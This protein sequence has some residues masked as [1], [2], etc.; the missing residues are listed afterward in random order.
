MENQAD[1]LPRTR[2]VVTVPKH[3]GFLDAVISALPDDAYA[4]SGTLYAPDKLLL[5]G[6]AQASVELQMTE[7]VPDQYL[8]GGAG[9]RSLRASTD[10]VVQEMKEYR[11]RPGTV[12]LNFAGEGDPRAFCRARRKVSIFVARWFYHGELEV[13]LDHPIWD[14]TG[15]LV[16]FWLGTEKRF[17]CP[18]WAERGAYQVCVSWYEESRPCTAA[19]N[20]LRTLNLLDVSRIK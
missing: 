10:P 17:R 15:S 11:R 9:G 20:F 4:I 12:R 2:R 14:D 6:Q 3:T 8:T 19:M 1:V 18:E 5:S 7:S 16:S 13:D